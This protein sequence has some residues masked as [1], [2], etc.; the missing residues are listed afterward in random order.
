[1]RMSGEWHYENGYLVGSERENKGGILFSRECYETNVLISFTVKSNLPATRDLNS[2][3]CA[4]WD[5]DND[6]L[7]S[8][9]ICGLHGW[10]DHKAGIKRFPE[11]G[12]CALTPLYHYTPGEEVKVTAGAINGH[13]FMQINDT[14]VMELIDPNPIKSKGHVGFT[15]YCTS[16]KIK[17]I[18]IREIYWEERNQIYKPEF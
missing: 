1:M 5:Y 7:K 3:Y 16:I 12:L 11:N 18:E 9:Y 13:N 17:D 4:E 14:L 15:P 2:L 6:Y 10:Y 8:A